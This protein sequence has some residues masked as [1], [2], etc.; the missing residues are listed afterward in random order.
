M[1]ER[2]SDMEH[3]HDLRPKSVQLYSEL[4]G[5]LYETY[6]EFK[7]DVLELYSRH[8]H[9]IQPDYRPRHFIEMGLMRGWVR[10]LDGDQYS[11]NLKPDSEV[12]P[13]QL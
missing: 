2:P 5:K 12:D 8:L 9:D 10:R 4:D 11:V 1:T 7:G 3:R 6:Y 13:N